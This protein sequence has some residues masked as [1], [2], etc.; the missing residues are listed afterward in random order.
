M[1]PS[2]ARETLA[3]V[4]QDGELRLTDTANGLEGF[5]R[6]IDEN[7]D[8][9]FNYVDTR[10]HVPLEHDDVSSGPTAMEVGRWRVYKQHVGTRTSG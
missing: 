7:G 1:T 6:T 3:A 5:T 8:A 10:P 4:L 9:V 2:A